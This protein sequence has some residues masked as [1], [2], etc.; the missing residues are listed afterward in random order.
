[1]RIAVLLCIAILIPGCATRPRAATG[2]LSRQ[3]EEIEVLREEVSLVSKSLD[4]LQRDLA[5]KGGYPTKAQARDLGYAIS[6]LRDARHKLAAE[7]ERLRKEYGV[8]HGPY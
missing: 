6:V 4:Q 1:M 5:A 7:A 8:S 3:R 2:D